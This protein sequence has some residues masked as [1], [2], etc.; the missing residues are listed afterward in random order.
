VGILTLVK[1][2]ELLLM[3]LLLLWNITGTLSFRN[4]LV[5]YS[6]KRDTY[7]YG[8]IAGNGYPFERIFGNQILE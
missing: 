5:Y 4:K 6:L 2:L 8:L 7:E 3:L 1:L